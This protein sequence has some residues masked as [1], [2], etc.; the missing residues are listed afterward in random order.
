M[1]A[2]I[3]KQKKIGRPFAENIIWKIFINLCLGVQYLHDIGFLHRDLKGMNVF[4]QKDHN[5]KIGDFGCAAKIPKRQARHDQ[6][7]VDLEIKKLR[8]NR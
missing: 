8:S 4:M 2:I 3:E 6:R 1:H 5:L 7:A